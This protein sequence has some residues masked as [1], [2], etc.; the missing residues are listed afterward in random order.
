MYP[1]V[2]ATGTEQSIV[3]VRDTVLIENQSSEDCK[4][5][6]KQEPHPQTDGTHTT[7][8]VGVTDL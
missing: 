4:M 5:Q 6:I 2:P 8:T 1:G 7:V 3:W